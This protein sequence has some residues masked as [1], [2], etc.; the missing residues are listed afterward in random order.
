MDQ[1]AMKLRLIKAKPPLSILKIRDDTF[2]TFFLGYPTFSDFN[3]G[4]LQYYPY[5]S[6]RVLILSNLSLQNAM[7][8]FY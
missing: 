4:S 1:V 2:P 7:R 6:I 8:T 5:L 3:P